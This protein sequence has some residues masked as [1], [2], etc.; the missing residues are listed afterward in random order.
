MARNLPGIAGLIG[1]VLTLGLVALASYHWVGGKVHILFPVLA[2]FFLAIVTPMTIIAIRHEVRLNRIKLID[3]FAR[4]FNFGAHAKDQQGKKHNVSFE[5]VKDKYFADLDMPQG[6]EPAISDVPRFPMMLHADWMLL[7][8]AVPY[9]VLCWFG[10][11]LLFAPPAEMV[12]IGL[13]GA[14]LWPS[15]LAVGGLGSEYAT[16]QLAV[17]W[18]LNV[19]TVALLA[20]AGAYFYTLRLMMRAVAVF[21]LSAITFLRAFAHIVLAMLLAVVIY[22][23]VPSGESVVQSW[24]TVSRTIL[25][26]ETAPT[27]V[28]VSPAQST[29]GPALPGAVEPGGS[30]VP[31]SSCAAVGSCVSGDPARGVSSLW[32]IVAFALG[33]IPDAAIQHVLKRSGLSFKA[34]YDEVDAHTK[35]IPLTILDGVDHFIAFRLEEANI[36]DVQNLATANPIMLHVETSY[37]IYET[38]DWVAQAQLC[39]VVG[40]DRFLLFKTLNI[41]TIFDL[42]RAVMPLAPVPV[43]A[44]ELAAPLGV[45]PG[46]NEILVMMVGRILFQDTSRDALL[47]QSFEL[48]EHVIEIEKAIGDT[49]AF[50]ATTRAMVAVMIDDLHVHRL[51]QIWKHIQSELGAESAHL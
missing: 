37:G 13:I 51:R 31:G 48:G 12:G 21:D 39:T 42:E 7:L 34:R 41:R 19:L 8:C 46:P 15:L 35:L 40:P 24:R 45:I 50:V 20:F 16:G 14:W 3:L 1:F 43:C 49:S 4:N 22:R 32:L 2:A 30:A 18:H 44:E 25:S 17:S 26:S 28:P 5:F 38:T 10:A 6:K 36:F 9:M 23:V 33:F 11:F 29:A 47:R 27:S